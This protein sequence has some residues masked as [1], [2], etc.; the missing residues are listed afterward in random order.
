MTTL[1]AAERRRAVLRAPLRVDAFRRL[2]AAMAVSIAGDWLY[3]VALLV[4]VYDRTHSAA[5]VGATTIVRLVPYVVFGSAGGA[6]ADRYD[7]RTV[8]VVSDVVRGV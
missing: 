7:R 6:L 8:M 3:N 5:W 4:F 2:L 1:A